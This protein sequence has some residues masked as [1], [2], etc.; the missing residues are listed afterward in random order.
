[1]ARAV[2]IDLGTTNSV[3]AVLDGGEPTVIANAAG[4]RTTPSVVAFAKN[5]GILV[6]EAAKRQA[7]TNADRTICSVKQHL[8]TDWRVVI[9]G[10][11]II[12]QQVSA[13]ILRKLKKDAEARLGDAI[14]DAVIAVPA[15]FS[16]A[17]RQAT[18]EAAAIAGIN[19]LRIVNEP[20]VSAM[21]YYRQK[22]RPAK[23]AVFDLGGGSLSVSVL[24]IGDGVVNVEATGGDNHLGGDDWDQRIVHWLVQDFTSGHGVDLSE[25]KTALRRLREAAET[26]KIELSQL[27]RAGISVPYIAESA[28][29]F[30]DLEA[31]LT[32]AQFQRMT[33]DLTGRCK[34]LFQQVISDA[35][36]EA[37]EIDHGVLAGGATRMPA[38]VGLVKSLTG[39]EPSKGVNPDEAVA[40]GA[41]LQAGVLKGEVKGILMLDVI[42]LSLGIETDSAHD[43]VEPDPVQDTLPPPPPVAIGH[44]GAFT[45]VVRR[46]TTIPAMRSAIFTTADD[47]Q[48][49]VLIRI[50]EG[51]H[52]VAADNKKLG[53]FELAGIVPAPRGVPRIEVCFDIDAN[54][55]VTVSATDLVTGTRQSVQATGGSALSKDDIDAMARECGRSLQPAFLAGGGERRLAWAGTG[56]PASRL[57][58]AA[59]AAK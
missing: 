17:Q 51:E 48:P 1:M 59:L 13:F 52:A 46:N 33:S 14:T 43:D 39:K 55:I 7:V 42:P 53:M 6:G 10:K 50:Y 25:D 20:V 57:A 11:T 34:A 27:S 22:D 37:G 3:L 32:R 8:G 2:G 24:S 49:S 28:R 38:V 36:V 23:I 18:R 16:D 56:Q 35:C 47:D 40:V 4:S 54:G 31:E 44:G 45:R 15:Y 26:A 41:C 29:G 9:D 21:A 58:A 19:V 12:A 5:T 30:L